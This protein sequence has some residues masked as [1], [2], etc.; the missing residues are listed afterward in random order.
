MDLATHLR[1]TE[2]SPVTIFVNFFIERSQTTK[3]KNGVETL[4]KIS[5][6]WVW[7]T[8]DCLTKTANVH[9]SVSWHYN[10]ATSHAFC[11][12]FEYILGFECTTTVITARINNQT[13]RQTDRHIAMH[14]AALICGQPII[15]TQMGLRKT[16]YNRFST[17]DP[18]SECFLCC[19]LDIIRQKALQWPSQFSFQWGSTWPV[20]IP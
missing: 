18:Q 16:G 8:N 20:V 19:H 17:I 7:R 5:I 1:F 2:G 10:S 14:I 4:P 3:V 13:D 9:C 6:A 11:I 15:Q 12:I